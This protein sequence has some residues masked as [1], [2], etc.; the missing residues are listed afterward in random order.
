MLQRIAGIAPRQVHEEM[1]I[2][3][4]QRTVETE[5][6]ARFLALFCTGA[7]ADVKDRGIA[8]QV[9]GQEGQERDPKDHHHRQ[10]QPAYDVFVHGRISTPSK[11]PPLSNGGRFSLLVWR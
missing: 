11:S 7:L 3:H 5:A 6:L 2:L 8:G 10:E 9:D 1:Q 4:V